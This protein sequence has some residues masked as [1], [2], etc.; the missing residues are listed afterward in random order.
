MIQKN[1]SNSEDSIV[2]KGLKQVQKVMG[3]H[4]IQKGFKLVRVTGNGWK[5]VASLQALK[6][7]G[8]RKLLAFSKL[9]IHYRFW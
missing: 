6:V 5:W 4:R 3:F 9:A 7:G 8:Q 1:C 2:E